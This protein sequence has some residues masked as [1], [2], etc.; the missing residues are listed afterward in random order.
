MHPLVTQS[1]PI[2][3]AHV[4]NLELVFTSGCYMELQVLHAE[5]LRWLKS[6]TH[7]GSLPIMH[8]ASG[9]GCPSCPAHLGQDVLQDSL[10]D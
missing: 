8:R 9:K 2:W 1:W 3:S 6:C 4:I 5:M 7:Q 10:S